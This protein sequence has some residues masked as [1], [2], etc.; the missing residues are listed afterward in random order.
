[1]IKKF[2]SKRTNILLLVILLA[3]LFF[4]T[5]KA[6][7]LFLYGHDQDLAGWFVRD[8]VFNKHLRLIGQETSTKGIFIGP[9]YYYLLVPFYAL[10]NFDPIGGIIL[11][12]LLGVFTI[13]SVYFVFNR[14]F[15]NKEGL[16]ASFIYAISF[17]AIFNDREV[18]PTMPV[19][20]WSIWFLYALDL[21]LKKKYKAGF[22]VSGILIGLI[23]HL[24]FAL[25]LVIPLL[26]TALYLSK[27]KPMLK[28]FVYGAGFLIALSTPLILFELKHGYP[29]IHALIASLTTDQG[30][31]VAGVDKFYR[32]LRLIGKNVRSLIYGSYDSLS[33]YTTDIIFAAI[34]IYLVKKK[35]L[36]K[37]LATL[38]LLWLGMYIA[39]FASYSKIVSEYYLNGMMV[40]F[41]MIFTLLISHYLKKKNL[42]IF[43]L[44]ILI[45]F[46]FLNLNK[47]F[48]NDVNESGYLQRKAVV[49]EIARD[50]NKHN[51]P[52][53]SASFITSPGNN[54]GYRYF[55]F[56]E[57][58]HVNAPSSLSPVY[59]IVFPLRDDI[60][61]D[62]TYGALGLIYPDYARYNISDVEKSCEGENPNLTEPM[63]GLPQ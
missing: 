58:L 16:V 39:F 21:I 57:N 38:I 51:Y 44:I 19:I 8:V 5:Y 27:G 36:G 47:F 32:V 62:Q 55:F 15:G 63:W 52:C 33:E 37:N 45:A 12:T 61:V 3:G 50:A 20:T 4:R 11:I 6:P 34:F 10:T 46:S 25:V 42:R 7:E 18:V 26:P 9:I 14:V 30:E 40:V 13:W 35:V 23:W 60:A 49:T 2:L 22:L 24:N 28:D 48:R 53:V 17:Y 59:T 1:M 31:V 41:L 43:G 56:L 29:Q 54:F